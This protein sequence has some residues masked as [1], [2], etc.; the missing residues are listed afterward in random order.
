MLVW[1]N[2]KPRLCHDLR[3][4]NALIEMD[5]VGIPLTVEVLQL[6]AKGK[7]FTKL[8]MRKGYWQIGLAEGS[9]K[10]ASF[11]LGTESFIFRRVPFGVATAPQWYGKQIQEAVGDLDGVVPYF[12]DIV[13]ATDGTLEDHGKQVEALVRRLV[14]L[15]ACSRNRRS[16]SWGSS[17]RM[18]RSGRNR[19]R[20]RSSRTGRRRGT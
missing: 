10:Y 11:T 5:N 20:R 7:W 13:V 18:G 4:L 12:D 6:A 17:C 9:Q 1:Q 16:S 2:G 14:E 19:R 3:G 8:D 15:S